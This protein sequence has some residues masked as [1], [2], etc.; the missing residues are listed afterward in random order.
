MKTKTLITAC[1]AGIGIYLILTGSMSVV[2]SLYIALGDLQRSGESV[3][4]T[5]PIPRPG[6]AIR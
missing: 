2:T 3:Y 4:A 5:V 6:H 1:F